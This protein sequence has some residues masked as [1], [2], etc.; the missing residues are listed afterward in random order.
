MRASRW[1]CKQVHVTYQVLYKCVKSI[2]YSYL[3]VLLYLVL[4]LYCCKNKYVYSQYIKGGLI[5]PQHKVEGQQKKKRVSLGVMLSSRHLVV[6]SCAGNE[7]QEMG[8]TT[9][10]VRV[11]GTRYDTY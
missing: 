9:V 1:Q 10:D 6:G 4:L 3:Y 2:W 8:I 7:Y 11:P 5:A